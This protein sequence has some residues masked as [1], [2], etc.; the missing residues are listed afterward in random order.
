MTS[1]AVN[2]KMQAEKILK[3]YLCSG[4]HRLTACEEFMKK[5]VEERIEFVCSKM[6]CFKCVGGKLI[7][8]E[9][10]SKIRCT[11]TLHHSLLH[12]PP[13]LRV[14]EQHSSSNDVT[15]SLSATNVVQSKLLTPVR[16]I[17]H[18]PCFLLWNVVPVKVKH[19]NTVQDIY[20]VLDQGSTS[21]FCDKSLEAKGNKQQLT[22]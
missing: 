20:A 10:K 7:F 11:G 18:L 9:C 15:H 21:C 8:H 12:K 14:P 4:S 19:M 2:N 6:L 5:S 17:L 16:K 3:C 22:L 1:V 13:K